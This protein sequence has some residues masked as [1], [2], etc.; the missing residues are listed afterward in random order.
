M[1]AAAR[2]ACGVGRHGCTWVDA[3][4]RVGYESRMGGVLHRISSMD[5]RALLELLE[6]RLSL[7]CITEQFGQPL[8]EVRERVREF[9]VRGVIHGN[10]SGASIDWNTFERLMEPRQV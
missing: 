9:V 3:A 2:S 4:Y 1:F 7:E 10:T 6:S 8:D 5:D